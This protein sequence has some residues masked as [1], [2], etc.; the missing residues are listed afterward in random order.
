[1][2]RRLDARRA[3]WV[4]VAEVM[5]PSTLVLPSAEI[6]AFETLDLARLEDLAFDSNGRIGSFGL[7]RSDLEA[8]ID[9][10]EPFRTSGCIGA[11]GSVACNRP[12]A[13]SRPGPNLRNYP[14][15]PTADDVE[16]IRLQLRL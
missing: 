8:I 5:A 6:E 14:F 3:T 1:M 11:D 7:L 16:R 4:D 2:K 13:N 15:P 12:F 9:T 10:G